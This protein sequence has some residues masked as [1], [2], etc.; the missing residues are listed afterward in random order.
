MDVTTFCLKLIDKFVPL[1]T[2]EK[3]SLRVDAQAW[4]QT[5]NPD[6]GTLEHKLKKILNHWFFRVL[7]SF[8]FIF[9]MIKIAKIVHKYRFST[10]DGG[11]I[12][13]ADEEDEEEEEVVYVD[14]DGNEIKD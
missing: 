10:D 11:Q 14:E 12:V 5:W 1:T 4:M 6:E 8:G 3:N 13:F 7:L 2:D 9:A